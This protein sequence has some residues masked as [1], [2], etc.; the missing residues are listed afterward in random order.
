MK[1]YPKQ[2]ICLTSTLKEHWVV[3]YII[4]DIFGQGK[5][6]AMNTF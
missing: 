5:A 6:A 1:T 2:N 4:S 3:L